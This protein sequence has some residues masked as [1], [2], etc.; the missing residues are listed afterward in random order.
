M[1]YAPREDSFILKRYIE[2]LDLEGK[3]CL[4]MGTGSGIQAKAMIKSGAEKVIAADI[5]PEASEEIPE[6][7]V[8]IESDLFENIQDK[9]DFITFNPPYLPGETDLKGSATWAGGK[10]GTE[11]ITRF[12]SQKGDYLNSGGETAILISSL[13]DNKE[14]FDKFNLEIIEE[15]EMFFEKLYLVKADFGT[16]L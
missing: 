11:L 15:H 4:D 13:S 8:F 5:N 2:E 9:F 3:K 14:L 10:N 12:L 7:S 6:E 1:I 16:D